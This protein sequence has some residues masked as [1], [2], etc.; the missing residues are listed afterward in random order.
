[1]G[2][3]PGAEVIPTALSWSV[4]F[5]RT[6]GPTEDIVRIVT[7]AARLPSGYGLRGATCATA[8]G[9]IA[10]TGLRISEAA[11]LSDPDVELIAGTLMVRQGKN[12]KQR[13][14]P[15]AASVVER[16]RA[17]R[18]ERNRLLGSNQPSFFQ[19]DGG[20]RPTDCGLRY[21]F[22]Q[23]CQRIG[24]REPQPFKKH[25]RGPRVHDLRHTFAV[26]TL[27]GWYRSGLDIDCE[28]PKLSAYLGHGSPANTYWYVEAVPE[29]MQLAAERAER[30]AKHGGAP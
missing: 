18:R 23:V 15:I 4:A 29:L 1:M 9:L 16:L 14:L 17:Y 21:N 11:G 27:L 19:F 25:G 22:A 13:Q 20:Q 24:L 7:E 2:G 26:R 5:E 10:A 8:F 12:R 3:D 28:M 6:V 30:S